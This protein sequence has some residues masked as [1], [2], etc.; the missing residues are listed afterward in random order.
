MVTINVDADPIRLFANK[1]RRAQPEVA[2][3]LRAQVAAAA[4]MVR[5]DARK[6]AGEFSKKIPPTIR[7]SA[8]GNVATVKVGT[9]AQPLGALYERKKNFRHPVGGNTNVWVDQGVKK[10]GTKGPNAG[11]KRSVH[12]SLDELHDAAVKVITDGVLEAID[13]V[14]GGDIQ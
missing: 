6:R 1:L 10:D 7:S 12:D 5:D 11:P 14:I 3:A 9:K 8:T 4:R 2:K 13:K